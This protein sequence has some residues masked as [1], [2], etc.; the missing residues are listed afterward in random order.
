MPPG[1][2]R[3]RGDRT[4][5]YDGSDG[6]QRPSPHRP[7]SLNLAQQNRHQNDGLGQSNHGQGQG[8]N[9]K[10]GEATGGTGGLNNR[11]VSRGGRG[12]GSGSGP[13]HT[14]HSNNASVASGSVRSIGVINAQNHAYR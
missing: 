4:Y 1:S 7:G 14:Q 11:R 13:V 9:L 5:S 2:K 8:A 10:G 6:S 3:K 12:G